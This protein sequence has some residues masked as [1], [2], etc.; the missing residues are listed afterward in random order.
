VIDGQLLQVAIR[1]NSG[2]G[3]PLLLFNGIG[4]NWELAKAVPRSTDEHDGNHL[5]RAWRRRFTQAAPAVSP[6]DTGA[7]C[8]RSRCGA[9]LRRD[10]R[11][12][13][14]LGRWNRAAVRA[15]ISKALPAAGARR[16]GARR[17][18]GAGKPF[19]TLEDGDAA[20]LYRQGLHE[21]DCGGTSMEE[22]FA[23]TRH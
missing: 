20:P 6:V 4:A 12:R 14:V 18:H 1:H 17:H 21:Q 5:R 19:C 22:P 9:R 7:A 2:S 13:C 11:C 10:R 8:R 3:P 23:A 15:S 16:N